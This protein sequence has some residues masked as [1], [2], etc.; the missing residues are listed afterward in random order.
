[1]TSVNESPVEIFA[2]ESVLPDRKE[3]ARPAVIHE[4]DLET[5]AGSPTGV[6]LGVDP[7]DPLGLSK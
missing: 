1:M 4:L 7:A 2:A 6:E 3:Y 5:R